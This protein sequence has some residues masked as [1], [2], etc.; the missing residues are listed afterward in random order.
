MKFWRNII[1]YSIWVT[2]RVSGLNKNLAAA[3]RT[4]CSLTD[5]AQY[6][7]SPANS[8]ANQK[9]KKSSSSSAA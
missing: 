4:T 8:Y 3:I 6:T 2:R 7:G 5:A 9:L 1:P